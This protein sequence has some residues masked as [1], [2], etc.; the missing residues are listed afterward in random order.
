MNCVITRVVN[1]NTK[2]GLIVNC[3]PKLKKWNV[4]YVIS[5][6]IEIIESCSYPQMCILNYVPARNNSVKKM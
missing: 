2:N 3:L 6:S 1:D 5:G 4:K